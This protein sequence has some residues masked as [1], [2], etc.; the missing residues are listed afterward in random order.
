MNNNNP[1]HDDES[2]TNL[3]RESSILKDDIR[4]E[5]IGSV[6]EAS[7]ALGLARAYSNVKQ[8][9][10]IILKIQGDLHNLMAQLAGMVQPNEANQFF[11]QKNVEWLQD[12]IVALK[13][14]VPLPSTFITPGD[15][16]P[17][18]AMAVARTCVRRAERRVVSL[19]SHNFQL[20]PILVNYLNRLSF[21]CFML[22]LSEYASDQSIS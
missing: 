21:V 9:K 15:N 18:G 19:R 22:E 6:D 14:S 2:L 10:E 16:I 11:G 5:A 1:V 12:V 7:A 20:D 13:E 4:I 3:I 8:N 17:G